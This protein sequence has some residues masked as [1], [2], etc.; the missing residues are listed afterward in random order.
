MAK[1]RLPPVIFDYIDGGAEDAITL[2]ANERVFAEVTFR[3]RQCVDTPTPDLQTRVLGTTLDVPFLLA[4]PYLASP[5]Q[6]YSTRPHNSNA[7][8]AS[9]A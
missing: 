5:P 7:S 2:R 3:P 1:R 6:G 8:N 4:V 9:N